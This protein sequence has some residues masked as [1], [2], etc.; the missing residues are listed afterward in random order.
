V[1]GKRVYAVFWDGRNMLVAA[2]DLDGKFLWK[3]DLGEF[4]SQHGAAVSPMVCDGKVIVTNDQDGSAELV[5]LDARTGDVAWRAPRRAFRA[6]YSTPF[7]IERSGKVKRLIV[8]STAGITS[9]DPEN[10]REEWDWR[11][12]FTGMALRTVA[13]PVLSHGLIIASSGDGSGERDTV[14]VRADGEGHAKKVWEKKRDMPYVPTMLASG[15]YLYWVHDKGMAGCM[16]AKTGKRVWLERLGEPFSASPILIDGKIYALGEQGTV[17]VYRA[18]PTFKLLAKNAVGEGV[19]ATP[20]VADNRLFIRGSEHLICIG[21]AKA[22]VP[23]GARAADG[24][25]SGR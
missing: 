8:A 22:G 17:F 23:R 2:H 18:S 21:K 9:Y 19:M 13:S 15:D 5:A 6:C 10:G 16:V 4:A 7:V 12:P 14:A 24:A 1:D 25:A 3:H 11:W 20:A